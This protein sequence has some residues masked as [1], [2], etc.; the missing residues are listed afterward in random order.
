MKNKMLLIAGAVIA[1]AATTAQA[2]SITGSIDMSGTVTLD[3]TTLGNAHATGGFLSVVVGGTPSGTFAQTLPGTGVFWNNFN[4]FVPTL[5]AGVLWG[6]TD[7]LGN[8]ITFHLSTVSINT[9]NN[10]F[11]NLLGTGMLHDSGAGFVDTAGTWSFT[12][13]NPTGGAAADFS[14]TFA[15]SNTSGVPDGGMSVVLL[16]LALAG[17]AGI[18]RLF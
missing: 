5:P 4:W 16:G 6:L 2:T 11:L 14:F 13:S 12:I 9:Q 8:S 3:S 18:R 1:M 17:M 7:S 10:F 15:N